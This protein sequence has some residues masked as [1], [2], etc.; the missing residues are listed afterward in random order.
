MRQVWPFTVGEC[1]KNF[2]AVSPADFKELFF[3]VEK[4]GLLKKLWFVAL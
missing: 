3:R 1:M 4:S 2:P